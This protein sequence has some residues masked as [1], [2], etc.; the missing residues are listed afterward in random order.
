MKRNFIYLEGLGFRVQSCYFPHLGACFSRRKRHPTRPRSRAIEARLS[1]SMLSVSLSWSKDI[2]PPSRRYLL[3]LLQEL[4]RDLSHS[5]ICSFP[6]TRPWPCPW[7]LWGSLGLRKTPWPFFGTIH[8]PFQEASTIFW[9]Y[10]GSLPG[11]QCHFLDLENTC[12]PP[13]LQTSVGT[14]PVFEGSRTLNML[15]PSCRNALW[16]KQG[17]YW[18]PPLSWEGAFVEPKRAPNNIPVIFKS[19]LS[20]RRGGPQKILKRRG[21][22]ALTGPVDEGQTAVV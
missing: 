3:F 19:T 13:V 16:R 14:V 4:L 12:A 6:P 18:S 8:V 1:S 20:G 10:P 7:R 21:G 17:K 9:H 5:E 15:L 2:L 22:P 11:G